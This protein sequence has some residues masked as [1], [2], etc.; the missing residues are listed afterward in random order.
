MSLM[1]L[2]QFLCLENVVIAQLIAGYQTALV[3][4]RVLR[5]IVQINISANVCDS[6]PV[7]LVKDS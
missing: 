1:K 7:F 2:G 3:L 5:V 6:L 4:Y